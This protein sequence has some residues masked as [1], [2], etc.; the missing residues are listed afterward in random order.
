MTNDIAYANR[1]FIPAA[2][3]YVPGW[4]RAAAAFRHAARDRGAL[5]TRR[6]GPAERQETDLFMPQGQPLGCAV[7]VHGGY[8]RAFDKS[9]WSHLAAGPLARGW[10]VAMPSYTLAPHARIGQIGAEI[11][12]AITDVAE[13]VEGPIALC[14]HSAGGQLVARMLCDPPLLAPRIAARILS[15]VPISPIGDLVPLMDTAMNADLR[16]D[17]EEAAAQSP[18]RLALG[19]AGIRITVW[20]GAEERPAFLDQAAGLSQ[21]WAGAEAGLRIDPGRHHFDVMDG[22]EN[23]GS[24]LVEA[25]LGGL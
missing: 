25:L 19:A 3:D 24:P 18:A 15:C 17:A 14:G 6:Y 12:D 10:A 16:I 13:A 8:W 7:F 1:D 9:L 21:A 2:D 5:R 23:A 11:A 4:E 22:L 20:V